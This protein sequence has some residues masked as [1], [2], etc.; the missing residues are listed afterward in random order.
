[1]LTLASAGGTIDGA[2]SILI[3]TQYDFVQVTSDNTNW[4][5]TGGKTVQS[6]GGTTLFV[7]NDSY[8]NQIAP[9]INYGNS[10]SLKTIGTT[11]SASNSLILFDLSAIPSSS[12]IHKA[13]LNVWANTINTSGTVNYYLITSG[14][15]ESAVTWNT[16]PAVGSLIGT[17]ATG[18]SAPSLIQLDITT[19]VQGWINGTITNYGIEIQG[20]GS[21][22]ILLRSKESNSGGGNMAYI[23]IF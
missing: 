23:T 8:V 14:W 1:M 2:N 7:S 16:T 15:A 17:V 20:V 3:N 12:V 18:T 5:I 19:T 22:N 11:G 10:L 6:F 21:T 4:Y 13:V 9:T